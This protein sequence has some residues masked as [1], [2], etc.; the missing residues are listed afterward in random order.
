MKE[1]NHEQAASELHELIRDADA[2]TLCALYEYAFGAVK[3]CEQS[4]ESDE[5]IV[6]YYD[7][8][9]P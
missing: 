4:S 8:L 7:G 2:D 5:F 1:I 3:S 6:E 9:E